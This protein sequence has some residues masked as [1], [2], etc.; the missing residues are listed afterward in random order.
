[1]PGGTFKTV[2]IHDRVV[3]Y[4]ERSKNEPSLA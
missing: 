1:M 3:G 4:A 2:I